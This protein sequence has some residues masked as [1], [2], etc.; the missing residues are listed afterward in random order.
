MHL[1]IF[2]R[3]FSAVTNPAH[4]PPEDLKGPAL[5]TRFSIDKNETGR[6]TLPRRAISGSLRSFLATGSAQVEERTNF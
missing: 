5:A 3:S 4:G 6:A 1:T 2:L